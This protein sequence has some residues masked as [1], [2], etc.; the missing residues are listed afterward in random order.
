MSSTAGMT[1]EEFRQR[2]PRE[3][4]TGAYI[5]DWDIVL[6]TD[7]QLREYYDELQQGALAV[8]T[9][10]GVD[11]KWPADKQRALTYCISNSFAARKPQVIE[12]MRQATDDG[13]EKLANVDFI[14]V[15]AEDATCAPDNTDVVFD[16]SSIANADYVASAFYPNEPR[17][18][19]N[20]SINL[21]EAF[22]PDPFRT[23]RGLL[24]HELGHALGFP[25]EQ[26]RPEA[27]QPTCTST[28]QLR[29]LTAYDSAS[30][31]HYRT[32]G[33]TATMMVF[34]ALDAQGAALLYGAPVANVAPMAQ[35]TT[36]ANGAIVGPTFVVEALVVDMDLAKVELSIDG[37]LYETSTAPPFSFTVIDL[38]EGPHTLALVATDAIGQVGSQAIA[39]TVALPTGDD[40]GGDPPTDADL[41]SG[42][43]ATGD[44]G[45]GLLGLLILGLVL[46]ANRR[47]GCRRQLLVAASTARPNSASTV[48]QAR[49]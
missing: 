10:N 24:S 44:A 47:C 17:D 49:G 23:L 13:W 22:Q 12:A 8:R 46:A 29:G 32:C 48:R 7:E 4:G 43:R 40:P 20:V 37:V 36:P 9:V 33:G 45:S 18:A 14:Y 34:T 2:V 41:S 16:V 27:M 5:V 25:H 28:A 30:I 19:R 42:C 38:A 21:A 26:T 31:M 6:E 1:F 3:P 39:I 35:L 15:P 11:A